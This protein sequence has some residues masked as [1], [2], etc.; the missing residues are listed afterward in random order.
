MRHL[1][2]L[3]LRS[4]VR[5]RHVRVL[6]LATILPAACVTRIVER[7]ALRTYAPRDTLIV[8]VIEHD[9]RL[10]TYPMAWTVEGGAVRTTGVERGVIEGLIVSGNTGEAIPSAQVTVDE[11][12]R[13]AITDTTG[14]FRITDVPVRNAVLQVQSLGFT[15][16]RL[17]LDLSSDSGHAVVVP[18]FPARVE[19]CASPGRGQATYPSI[20]ARIL[21]SR[22]GRAPGGVPVTVRISDGD[23]NEERTAATE[24]DSLSIDS[25][26]WR[27]G[28]YDVT[29]HAPSFA[30]WHARNVV[31]G[32]DHC[33]SPRTALLRV[34]LLP[35]GRV[36]GR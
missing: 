20:T 4:T 33:N 26:P 15:R 24:S 12:N 14:R 28:S 8:G 3:T 19:I 5:M 16:A 6:L 29:V 2:M 21:D 23:Y 34:Y 13:G 35:A 18:L 1:E 9:L 36:L 32:V 30:P 11:T 27:M 31:V 25:G 10:A 17:R 22:T 7:P